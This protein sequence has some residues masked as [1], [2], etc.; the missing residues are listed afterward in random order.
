MVFKIKRLKLKD[1]AERNRG[2]NK[3]IEKLSN[4]HWF[5][6][7][8]DDYLENRDAN[9]ER[10][11]KDNFSPS[12]AA[13]CPRYIQFVM[14]AVK[15]ETERKG[16]NIRKLDAGKDMHNR[17][18]QYFTNMGILVGSEIRLVIENPPI[19]GFIDAIIKSGGREWLVELKS[20]GHEVGGIKWEDFRAP[21]IEHEVQWQL[22]AKYNGPKE[23]FILVENK[24]T[25]A[26][27]IFDRQLDEAFLE[28]YLSEWTNIIN[29]RTSG[30]IVAIPEGGC[31]NT[32]WCGF[33]K[34]C[35]ATELGDI[36]NEMA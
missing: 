17:Y 3:V 30:I 35:S 34:L 12:L 21:P 10:I 20:R 19:H 11:R 5:E 26:I 8:I 29:A 22:Y 16:L 15:E 6:L 7:M 25:N 28:P 24:S 23:G 13:N 4:K 32:R 18:Q 31:P 9:R 27:K 1:I 36:T 33:K 2:I 14:D